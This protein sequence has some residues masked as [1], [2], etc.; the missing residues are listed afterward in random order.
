MTLQSTPYPS[1]TPCLFLTDEKEWKGYILPKDLITFTV[2]STFILFTTRTT[3]LN[4][5]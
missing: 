1:T 2:E 4:F 3:R 5:P